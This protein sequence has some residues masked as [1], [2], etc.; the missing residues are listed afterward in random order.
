MLAS[1][2]ELITECRSKDDKIKDQEKK[3]CDLNQEKNKL[4]NLVKE[5]E[6]KERKGRKI[7]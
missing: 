2:K 7:S 1:K 3:I 4:D 6:R 5:Y